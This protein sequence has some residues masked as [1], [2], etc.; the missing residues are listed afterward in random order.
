MRHQEQAIL[1][2]ILTTAVDAIIVINQRGV[3]EVVNDATETM[4]GF[5]REELVGQNVA[6]LMPEPQR[7]EHDD[8][9]D[10]Y[11]RTGNAKIIGAGREV[12]G[13]RKDGSVFPIHLAVSEI[14]VG[15]RHLFAGIVRDISELKATEK[16]LS[17]L[18]EQLDRRV[19]E[20]TKAL[21][22]AKDEL[23]KSEKLAFLGQVSGGIAHEIKNPLSVIRTSAYL[24]KQQPECDP[25][26]RLKHLDR[27]ERQVHMI[28]E[29]VNA[30]SSFTRLPESQRA[31]CAT[32]EILED[33]IQSERIPASIQVIIE[34]PDRL[35]PAMIDGSQLAIV[36]R[37]LIRN[38]V[39]AMPDGGELHFEMQ[40][41]Q[42]AMEIRVRDNGCGISHEHIEKIMEPLFSTKPR[43]MGL[44]LAI[45]KLILSRNDSQIYVTSKASSG[46]EFKLRLPLSEQ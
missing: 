37:N 8:Y 31:S 13:K 24:L 3:M 10:N 36:L 19:Q 27:I 11:H 38:A 17:E 18:N 20:R 35:P 41:T 16:R 40:A 2:A 34:K 45:C 44:G 28:D 14:R 6:M 46:T 32:Q 26:K 25:S 4:F 39:E 1:A 7:S 15:D 23:V 12:K 29:V 42:D 22:E 9:L 43:G 21:A 33:A 5:R 30:L